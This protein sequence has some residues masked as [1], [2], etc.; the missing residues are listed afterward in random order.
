MTTM[1]KV[2]VVLNLVLAGFAFGSASALLGAQDDYKSALV[3]TSKKFDVLKLEYD[4]KKDELRQELDQQKA[5]ASDLTGAKQTADSRAARFETELSQAQEQNRTLSSGNATLSSEVSQ[6]RQV[7]ENFDK[8]LKA[9]TEA[10][11]SQTSLASEWQ[12]KYQEAMGSAN[13]M[14]QELSN[15]AEENQNYAALTG[16]QRKLIAELKFELGA[17]RKVHGPIRNLSPGAPG[18][19][20]NVK[21]TDIGIFVAISVGSKDNVRLGDEYHLSRGARYVGKIDIIRVSKDGAIGR[22]DEK[23]AGEVAPPKP[24]DKAWVD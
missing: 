11:T 2:F 21:T 4:R 22:F 3:D 18:V 23:F 8:M 12:R 14:E 13:Q 9:A 19:V 17:Y 5:R 16:D 6:L 20:L 24:D 15:A 10:M 1:A 7:L